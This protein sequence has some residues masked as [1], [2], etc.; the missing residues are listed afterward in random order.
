[1]RSVSTVSTRSLKQHKTKTSHPSKLHHEITFLPRPPDLSITILLL[2]LHA[3]E[4]AAGPLLHAEAVEDDGAVDERAEEDEPL[5]DTD[6]EAEDVGGD[7]D[8]VDDGDDQETRPPEELEQVEDEVL[9]RRE[10]VAGE[11]DDFR[12]AEEEGDAC[13]G[14]DDGVDAAVELSVFW[15]DECGC[16]ARCISRLETQGKGKGGERTRWPLYC[17]S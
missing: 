3:L 16:H 12:D 14:E 13:D 10:V 8:D 4:S 17:W 6:G 15:L 9:G 11:E 5:G 7:A 1:M 2:L